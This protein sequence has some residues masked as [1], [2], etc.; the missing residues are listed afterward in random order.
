VSDGLKSCLRARRSECHGILRRLTE[1]DRRFLRRGEILDL[2]DAY[3]ADASP[4]FAGSPVESCLRSTQEAVVHGAMLYLAT[5]P[6]IA[7]WE[8]FQFDAE[9]VEV[10]ELTVTGYLKAKERIV[11]GG[12]PFDWSPEIDLAPFGPHFPRRR[13]TR[14]IGRGVEFL[15]RHLSSQLFLETG[16]GDRLLFDFLKVHAYAGTPLMLN[17]RISDPDELA[18][19]LVSADAHLARHD[20]DAP[21]SEVE[22]HLIELGFEAGWGRSVQRIRETMSLLSGILE[23][24]DHIALEEFLGRIP[25]IFKLAILSPH[26]F[27]G[28]SGVLGLPDTGGQVVYILDQVRALEK[29]MHRRIHEQGL[30]I[31]P[32]I[33]V[34]TR[35]IPEARGTSCDQRQERILGTRNAKILRIPFRTVSGEIV[36]Q[37]ISRF[38]IWPYLERF[39]VDAEREIQA[40]ICGRPDLIIGNYSDGNLVAALMAHRLHVTQCNIAHALEKTKYVDSDLYWRDHDDRYHF[41]S[42]FTADLIS[43]NTADFIIT[44]TYQEI[45]GDEET[46]GQYESYRTFTMPGLY[47]VVEGIDVF[48]P[49]FNI[50]SPG[51]DPEIFFP[52]TEGGRLT[53][54]ASEIDGLL[55]GGADPTSA[56]GELADRGKPLLFAMSRLDRIKNLTGLVQWFGRS[57]RLRAS[58]NLVVVSGTVEK[59]RSNDREEREE[60]DRMHRAFDE[61]RLDGEVRWIGRFLDK[62]LS[63]E[64]Y[65]TIADRRGAFVQPALFEGFGLTVVEAMVSGLPTFATRNGGPSEIIDHGRSGFHIDPEHGDAAAESMAEFFERCR[66]E[67][68][69]WTRFSDAAVA[70]VRERY[71]W[72]LY[73]RRLMTLARVYGFWKFATSLERLDS[74]RYLELLYGLLY[75]RLAREIER[76]VPEPDEREAAD[77]VR[78]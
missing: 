7:R 20:P 32:T 25:M 24:P 52:F 29:E 6:S 9:K 5:R 38:E 76:K 33:L 69:Y 40:E 19:A 46:E 1:R 58:A 4:D 47:R 70:R 66:D 13:E 71:T 55:F 60:I 23:A 31:E 11:N 68:S 15:N 37:W 17:H 12:D 22:A 56:R 63:G 53:S 27:F 67:P 48:D 2:L 30:D 51:A 16:V 26:G 59:S 42:Q 74:R 61:H 43:M 36:P 8:F 18:R 41:S 10:E 65:R 72:E 44:S 77:P 75:R 45:A 54:L 3:G 64:I 35:L 78:G 73:A 34:V 21:W 39:S 57:K 49:K 62:N 50:V 28:Q 14:S